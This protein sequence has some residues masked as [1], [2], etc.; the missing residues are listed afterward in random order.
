MGQVACCCCFHSARETQGDVVVDAR[1]WL[2]I[3]ALFLHCVWSGSN[4]SAVSDGSVGAVAA[5]A[6]W[7]FYGKQGGVFFFTQRHIAVL[8]R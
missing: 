4:P 1:G 7:R 2:T 5:S 8:L 3:V 6:E